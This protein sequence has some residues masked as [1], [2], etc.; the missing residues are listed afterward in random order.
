MAIPLLLGTLLGFFGA[1]PVAGPISA[2]VL[3]AGLRKQAH[4]GRAVALGAALAESVYVLL[5]FLGFSLFLNS[6]PWILAWSR[7]LAS[8]LLIGLGLYFLFSKSAREMHT[9]APLPDQ[10]KGK[11]RA[12][13]VGFGVSILNPTL[14]ATWTTAITSLYSYHFF[15]YSVLNAVLFSLGVSVGI[16]LWFSLMLHLIHRNHDR[17]NPVW[18]RRMLAGIGILLLSL[19]VW[20][21]F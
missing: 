3:R 4:R 10:A 5:A 18:I 8:V 9:D 6:V 14:M 20:N 17:L 2:L 1:I 11:K 13:S 19:G 21:L 16:V 15:S 7:T 12:F